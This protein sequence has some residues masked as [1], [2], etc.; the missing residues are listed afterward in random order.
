MS[1]SFDI[2]HADAKDAEALS[3]MLIATW[4]AT[5]DDLIGKSEVD[6]ITARWH[7]PGVLAQQIADDSSLNLLACKGDS[8][9]GH[10]NAVPDADTVQLN[11]LYVHPDFHG[12]G[13]GSA[14]LTHVIESY[15]AQKLTLEVQENNAQAIAFYK[16]KGFVETG[17][18]A[19]CGGDSDVPSILMEHIPA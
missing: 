10:A 13:V 4:H 15:P 18:S 3:A 2:R 19:H 17:R 7:A 5:Y 1:S 8:I 16:A 12:S 14:L 11:R 6:A 9:V